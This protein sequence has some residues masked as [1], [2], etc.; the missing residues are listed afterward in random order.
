MINSQ[1]LVIY[2]L[3]ILKLIFFLKCLINKENLNVFKIKNENLKN[4]F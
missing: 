3:E 1:N 4:I 2:L